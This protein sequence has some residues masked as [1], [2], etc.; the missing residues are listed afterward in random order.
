MSS[1]RM[2][3]ERPDNTIQQHSQPA[4]SE[5]RLDGGDH[6]KR[7]TFK[8]TRVHTATR[9]VLSTSHT[10]SYLTFFVL[11]FTSSDLHHIHF[12]RV[13]LDGGFCGVS[14]R[15]WCLAYLPH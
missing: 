15:S 9:I 10:A 3:V 7:Q 2:T 5:F 6:G 11:P 1:A 12:H 13:V 8:R 14:A 4:L